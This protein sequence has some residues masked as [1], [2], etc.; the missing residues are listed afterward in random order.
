MLLRQCHVPPSIP[1]VKTPGTKPKSISSDALVS[2]KATAEATSA[3]AQRFATSFAPDFYRKAAGLTISSIGM[4][5]YLGECDDEEDARYVSVLTEGI[6]SGLNLLDTAINYRC[7]RSERAVGTAVRNAVGSG[8]ASRDEIVICTKAGY[9]P[10]DGAPPESRQQYDEYLDQEYFGRGTMSRSELVAGGHCLAPA[11]LANQVERSRSNLGIECIDFF[12]VHNPEQQLDSVDRGRFRDVML[13]AFSTLESAVAAGTVGAYGCATWNG[14]RTFAANRNY[15]SLTELVD[16]ARE[17]GGPDHH[18]RVVQLPV[19]LAMTEA[20]RAPTQSE[21]GKNVALLD[22]A[23]DLG[24]SV[25]ASAALMQSQLA[26]NLPGAV[27]S[28]FPAFETDAQRAIAF[29]RSLPVGA[30]LVGMRSLGHL[31]ENLVAGSSAGR[32]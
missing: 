14:F 28:L 13:Q 23:Q 2:G 30:A 9:V 24:I 27:R 18:F 25:V 26:Q 10:L 21:N 8:L 15:L 4:G 16:I 17:A 1:R 20:V 11:F 7:Q 29:V 3:F 31:S 5:T 19:N 22:L 12:Y 32:A 6:A